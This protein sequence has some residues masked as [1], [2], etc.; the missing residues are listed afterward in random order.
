MLSFILFWGKCKVLQVSSPTLYLDLAWAVMALFP[1]QTGSQF[2]AVGFADPE[3][4]DSSDSSR[5]H[6][7]GALILA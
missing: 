2:I 3:F 1:C 4:H 6:S 7:R 5:V